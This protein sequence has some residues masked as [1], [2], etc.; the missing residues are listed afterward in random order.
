M[1]NDKTSLKL[2]NPLIFNT[3]SN[4]TTHPTLN[5]DENDNLNDNHSHLYPTTIPTIHHFT[6]QNAPKP[7]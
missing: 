2:A 6:T 3:S 5:L 4:K 1:I 7:Q